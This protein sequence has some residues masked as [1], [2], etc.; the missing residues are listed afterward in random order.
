LKFDGC[1]CVRPLIGDLLVLH[2]LFK[3]ASGT[4]FSPFNLD[5]QQHGLH[6]L[7]DAPLGPISD[8]KA[9]KRC[10]TRRELVAAPG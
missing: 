8:Y 1:A 2:K 9:C 3:L 4:K 7:S 6:G 10:H 5:R